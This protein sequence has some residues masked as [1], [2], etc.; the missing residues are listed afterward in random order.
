MFVLTLDM[1]ASSDRALI[2]VDQQ[3]QTAATSVT[4]VEDTARSTANTLNST[5]N[6]LSSASVILR[7]D[8]PAALGAA[9]QALVSAQG[10]ARLIDD[11]LNTLAAIP[12]LNIRYQPETPLYVALGNVAKSLDGLPKLTKDLGASLDITAADLPTTAK[13]VTTM[14]DTLKTSQSDMRDAQKV[15]GGFRMELFRTKEIVTGAQRSLSTFLT[16]GAAAISFILF[17]L[18]VVQLLAL[19]KGARWLLGK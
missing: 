4:S 18:G 8:V 16:Y 10:S 7:Q 11:V 5:R 9:Q 19:V 12:L 3:L 6:S 17:W 1:L 15:V 13:G 14:A 2:V